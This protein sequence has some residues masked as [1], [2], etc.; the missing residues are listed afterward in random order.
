MH[1]VRKLM[2][3]H[4]QQPWKPLYYLFSIPKTKFFSFST[5]QQMHRVPKCQSNSWS[6]TSKTVK[7]IVSA[8]SVGISKWEKYLSVCASDCVATNHSL[9]AA[10]YQTNTQ[11]QC[12][13]SRMYTYKYLNFSHSKI[14]KD[15]PEIMSWWTF[16]E[17][18]D[19]PTKSTL[20]LSR[21]LSGSIRFK[22]AS[23]IYDRDLK[24]HTLFLRNYTFFRECASIAFFIHY[25]ADTL[26]A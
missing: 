24:S 12:K 5:S 10:F 9:R 13:R 3:I 19:F 25:V 11:C 18:C 23:R 2:P 15:L 20:L 26:G 8:R 1:E 14:P 7:L 22:N 17:Q 16:S 4:D 6:V 21:L